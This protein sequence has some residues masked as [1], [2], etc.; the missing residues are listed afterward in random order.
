MERSERRRLQKELRKAAPKLSASGLPI[1]A[2][3]MEIATIALSIK[4][5]LENTK[6]RSRA[7]DAAEYA[8]GIFDRSISSVQLK[9]TLGCTLGCNSCC[10]IFTSATAPEIFAIV[11]SL[12]ASK[13]VGEIEKILAQCQPLKGKNV[14]ARFGAQIPCPSLLDGG[15]TVYH[16]RPLACRQCASGSR[17]AC[18]AA[19]LGANDQIPYSAAH[20]YSGNNAKLCLHAALEAN[21]MSSTAYELGEALSIALQLP[22]AESRWLSGEAVFEGCQTDSSRPSEY[23]RRVTYIADAIQ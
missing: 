8:G 2:Q 20:I 14:D 18:E 4:D 12:K 22:D 15:C 17:T 9:Y 1:E 5:Q 19:F 21:G 13:N 10:H 7:S 23:A 6:K 11:R 3:P 16:N